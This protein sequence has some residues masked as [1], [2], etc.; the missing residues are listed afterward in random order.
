MLA[1]KDSLAIYWKRQYKPEISREDIEVFIKR[2]DEY[3]VQFFKLEGLNESIFSQYNKALYGV[4]GIKTPEG[5]DRKLLSL[6]RP[7]AR[8]IEEELPDY[9]RQT[10]DISND[11]LKLRDAFKLSKSPLT[12]IFK[13]IPKA[14]GF[15]ELQESEESKE[16]VEGLAKKLTGALRELKYTHKDLLARQVK[17]LGNALNIKP[18]DDELTLKDLRGLSFGKLAGLENF[19][20]DEA[21][22][23]AFIKRLVSKFDDDEQWLE[24]VLLFLGHK[25]TKKW[26]DKDK[27][28]AEYRLSQFSKQ[29]LDLHTL[30]L[31]DTKNKKQGS[32]DFDVVLLKT[33][34]PGQGE[35]DTVVT[36]DDKTRDAI[37]GVKHKIDSALADVRHD[38]ELQLAALAEVVNEYLMK[39]KG[40]QSANTDNSIDDV[41]EA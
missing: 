32:G 31:Q 38:S 2:P 34:K 15:K 22:V 8:F 36:I 40:T 39:Y 37:E 23:K 4:E 11:A 16:L 35:I 14:L 25:P 18:V 10:K 21:G 1:Y 26:T 7:L 30:W 9:T 29:L 41:E 20:I 17:L 19:T 5:K 24:S 12:L 6:A 3:T 13:E 33:V 27:S 28:I